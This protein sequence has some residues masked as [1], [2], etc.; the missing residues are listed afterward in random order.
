MICDIEPL[1]PTRVTPMFGPQNYHITDGIDKQ[2]PHIVDGHEVEV[3]YVAPDP[4]EENRLPD[5]YVLGV[6]ISNYREEL[7]LNYAA[8]DATAVTRSLY[9]SG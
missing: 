6:G 1:V 3:V 2:N 7:R 5:L 4:K 8:Q 9:L